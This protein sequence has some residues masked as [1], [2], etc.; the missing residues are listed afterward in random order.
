MRIRPARIG[1][2]RRVI[3]QIDQD[4]LNPR[5]IGFDPNGFGRKGNREIVFARVHESAGRFGG[6]IDDGTQFD[7]LLG[8]PQ[9][10]LGDPGDIQKI[11][12]Q[13]HHHPHLAVDD[14]AGLFDD[15]VVRLHLPED[16]QGIDDRRQ[17]SRLH[18]LCERRCR[19]LPA[20][21]VEVR[22]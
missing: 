19:E 7:M 4:L 11:V 10:P 15:R 5:G 3:Q 13:S 1:V 9:F 2:F 22:G 21:V 16:A 12:H 18:S 20:G 6:V 8:Q 17:K 14:V